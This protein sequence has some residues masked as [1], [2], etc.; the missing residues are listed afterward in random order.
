MTQAIVYSSL[1]GPEVLSLVDLP[2]PVAGDGE[3]VV[4]LEAVGV[5]PIDHKLRSGLRPSAPIAE[6][7]RIG[8]DGAGVITAVGPDVD[9]F[10]VGDP[11]VVFGATGAYATDIAVPV[12]SAQPR[13]AS[14]TAAEGAA[15]GI[16]VA[17]AYQALRSLGVRD[18]DTLLVHA[19]SGA[20]GQAAIQLATLW[21]ARVIATSSPERFD[22]VHDLGAEPIAYG[23]G[24]TDRVRAAAPEGITV[25]LDAAGTDEAIE[26]SLALA[27]AARI[28]TLVRGG[29][30][31][32]YGIRAFSGGA[33]SPLTAQQRAWRAEAIPVTL[34]LLAAGAF[35][36][37]LGPS[38]ALGDAA[39][40][41]RAVEQGAAG[42]VILLP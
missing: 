32:G 14:V 5:N 26:T 17:T 10:R 16:P 21:G 4:R 8:T 9:G 15:L 22:R 30:A 29:D 39:A 41:H 40:A 2:H 38:F 7:R 3:V 12:R 42:K 1:G 13:P 24:L 6:P 20:V 11:V 28:A 33:P 35:S 37:E 25:A 23:E 31:A 27:P 18:G 36:V 34:A 19:G